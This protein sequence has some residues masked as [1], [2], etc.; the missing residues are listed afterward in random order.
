[1]PGD[2]KECRQHAVN[3]T[4]LACTADSPEMRD[5][6]ASLATAWTRLANELELTQ[7]LLRS[8]ENSSQPEKLT[9]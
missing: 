9:G 1:M 6:F 7:A 2:P 3:C 4:Q 5:H 8:V